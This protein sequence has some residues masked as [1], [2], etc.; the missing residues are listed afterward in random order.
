VPS[1]QWI[2]GRYETVE[3]EVWIPESRE[4]VWVPAL[5]ETRFDPCGRAYQVLVRPGAWTVVCNPGHFE[6][7]RERIWVPGGHRTHCAPY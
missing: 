1:R 4:K 3:R 2:A 5:Y 7:R 6:T